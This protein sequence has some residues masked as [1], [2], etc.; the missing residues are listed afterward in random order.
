MQ[1]DQ[2][3]SSRSI[4]VRTGATRCLV[5]PVVFWYGGNALPPY[6]G[7]RIWRPGGQGSRGTA[8]ML[9]LARLIT[10]LR[11]LSPSAF[12]ASLR[13]RPFRPAQRTPAST[14]CLRLSSI[15]CSV[16]VPRDHSV[17]VWLADALRNHRTSPAL[18]SFRNWN[19]S[20]TK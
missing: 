10:M 1:A 11:P 19:C 14:D 5:R 13:L 4:N 3:N 9:R 7:S 16:A 18:V 17:C 8:M 15:P 6:V 20:L 2:P 12:R